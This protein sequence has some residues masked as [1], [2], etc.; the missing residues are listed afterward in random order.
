MQTHKIHTLCFNQN[1]EKVV[2]TYFI[3]QILSLK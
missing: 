3:V 1:Y 2:E